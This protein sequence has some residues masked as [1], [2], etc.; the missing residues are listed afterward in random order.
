MEE[1]EDKRSYDA[2]LLTLDEYYDRREQRIR[3]CT[4]KELA[5][6]NDKLAAT[7]ALPDANGEEHP[8]RSFCIEAVN[9]DTDHTRKHRFA[10]SLAEGRRG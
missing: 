3:E 10:A 9:R 2:G 1:S 4:E 5:I 7:F 6:L 8:A